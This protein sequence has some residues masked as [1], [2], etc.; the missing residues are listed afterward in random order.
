[1]G[2]CPFCYEANALTE[3]FFYRCEICLCD[4]AI[5]DFRHNPEISLMHSYASHNNPYFLIGLL[6]DVQAAI[7]KKFDEML[8][9][10]EV[11]RG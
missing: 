1:M 9:E 8:E 11:E 7:L 6:P 4:P 5:C 10:L 3:Q 2:L